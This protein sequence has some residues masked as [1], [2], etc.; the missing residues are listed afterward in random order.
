MSFEVGKKALDFLIANSGNR[1]NLEVDFF[2]GEP[3]MNW[4]VV[5]TLWH[6]AESRRSFTTRSFAL[7]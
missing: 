1:R 5:R 2:G 3:L 7:R 6:T 4:Q